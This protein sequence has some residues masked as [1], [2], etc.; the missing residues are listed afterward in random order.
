MRPVVEQQLH[1]PVWPA[2]PVEGRGLQRAAQRREPIVVDGVDI[3]P[4]P[5][6][7]PRQGGVG[8]PTRL[9]QG[10]PVPLVPG[11]QVGAVGGQQPAEPQ[12]VVVIATTGGGGGGGRVAAED[13]H[14]RLLPGTAGIHPRPVPQVEVGMVVEAVPGRHVQRRLAGL[15]AGQVDGSPVSQQQL[16]A[17]AG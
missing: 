8:G 15:L 10:A 3:G 12:E 14:G 2:L 17:P 16:G 6:Q 7:E 13:A 1:G 5:Q 11:V 9:V 4:A